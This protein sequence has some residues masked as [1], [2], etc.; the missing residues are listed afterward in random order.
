MLTDRSVRIFDTHIAG[1]RKYF[2]NLL[3][4]RGVRISDTPIVGERV[5]QKY[6]K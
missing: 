4:D 1:R 3:T 5:S 2:K 6:V